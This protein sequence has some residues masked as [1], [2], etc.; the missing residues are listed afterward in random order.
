LRRKAKPTYGG[1]LVFKIGKYLFLTVAF[2]FFAF[3]LYWMVITAFKPGREWTAFPPLFFP[4]PPTLKNF[5]EGLFLMHGLK[6][7]MDSAIIASGNMA[8]TLSLGMLAGY[9]FS[10]FRLGE[11]L[12]FFILSQRFAPPA[13]FA[14]AFFIL[15]DKLGL[16]DTY[17]AIIL[18]HTTFNLPF[19]VWLMKTYFDGVP[20]ALDE[21]AMMDGC[22]PLG[23]FF[24][25]VLPIS[26]PGVIATGALLF[27]FSWNEFLLA[28]FL[29]RTAVTPF[30]VLIPK[31]YGGH[32]ILYGVV[33][34]VAFLA[35]IPPIII[36]TLLHK[37]L[38]RGLT[39]GYVKGA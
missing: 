26:T 35:S 2:V 9:A 34:A 25:V 31:F 28:L 6:G 23:A 10:R 7:I 22:S 21:A 5:Y 1:S 19:A 37:Y 27:M 36:I 38:V 32:D 24:R 13:A 4:A 3:P 11:N 33:S 14:V 18:A 16:L 39:L 17:I 20:K 30:V 29:S 12:A 15:F 8:L